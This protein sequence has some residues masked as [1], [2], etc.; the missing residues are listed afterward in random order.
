[1]DEAFRFPGA[2]DRDVPMGTKHCTPGRQLVLRNVVENREDA[3][4]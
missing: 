3:L 4:Q 2:T 1:M